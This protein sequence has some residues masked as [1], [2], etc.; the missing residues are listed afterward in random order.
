MN[1]PMS[2]KAPIGCMCCCIGYKKGEIAN[3]NIKR[4]GKACLR[5]GDAEKMNLSVILRQIQLE[6]SHQKGSHTVLTALWHLPCVS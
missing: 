2:K 3:T 1:W 6:S 4:Y 5:L